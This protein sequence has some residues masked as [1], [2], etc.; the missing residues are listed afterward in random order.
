MMSSVADINFSDL[1][2]A[3]PAYLCILAMPFAYSIAEGISLGVI[4]W[5]VLSLA[6]GRARSISPIMYLLTLLFL[7]KYIFL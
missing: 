4:S 5:T 3:I 7:A 1:P 6:A 2:N